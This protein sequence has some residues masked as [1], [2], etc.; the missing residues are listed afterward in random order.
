MI[1]PASRSSTAA[2]TKSEVVQGTRSR[3]GSAA[4]SLETWAGESEQ[5]QRTGKSGVDDALGAPAIVDQPSAAAPKRRSARPLALR[6]TLQVANNIKLPAVPPAPDFVPAAPVSGTLGLAP[7][8][9]PATARGAREERQSEEALLVVAVQALRAKHNATAALWALETY[10]ARYPQGRLFV[11]AR[12]LRVD[13]LTALGRQSEALPLLD[14][15]D[16]DNVPGGVE[17]HLQRGEL[18]ATHGRL[19]EAIEDFAWVIGRAREQATIERAL[20]ERA[21]A[22]MRA[23][24]GAGARS[25]ASVYLRRFP[26]GRFAAQ[27]REMAGASP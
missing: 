26:Q 18:R 13:A 25:D 16:L 6:D 10:E 22:R 20:G 17:R 15:L 11:E 14:E 8:L 21:Q 12:V 5:T 27:A 24:D 1:R 3:R 7:V 9:A 23:G 4:R 2:P 19:R